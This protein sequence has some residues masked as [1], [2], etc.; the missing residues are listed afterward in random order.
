MVAEVKYRFSHK[1]K[2][3]TVRELM[4]FSVVSKSVLLNRL[5]SGMDI[6]EALTK[7]VH[8]VK[9]RISVGKVNREI[10]AEKKKKKKEFKLFA[11]C[12]Y[13]CNAK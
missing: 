2:L 9:D 5:K 4:P 11:Q 8:H 7:K 3:M 1:G 6:H 12:A 10:N 13:R